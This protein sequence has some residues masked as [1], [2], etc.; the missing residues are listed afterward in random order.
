[1]SLPKQAVS[2]AALTQMES[3][4][5]ALDRT[6]RLFHDAENPAHQG[7]DLFD[8]AS[9]GLE[10]ERDD[11]SAR[12]DSDETAIQWLVG[13]TLPLPTPDVKLTAAL[14]AHFLQLTLHR[15]DA[16]RRE[17]AQRTAPTAPDPDAPPVA[18]PL[19]VGVRV[20]YADGKV[21]HVTSAPY[22]AWDGHQYVTGTW[23]GSKAK[24]PHRQPLLVVHCTVLP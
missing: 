18:S 11:D 20:A 19:A 5:G 10:I 21:Y 22:E 9:Y 2:W 3:A 7:W 4:L 12:F 16:L 15:L 1:M 14:A 13:Q 24:K 23:L 6:V 8:A 17:M